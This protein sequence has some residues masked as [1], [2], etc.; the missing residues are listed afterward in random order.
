MLDKKYYQDKLCKFTGDALKNLVKQNTP[1]FQTEIRYRNGSPDNPGGTRVTFERQGPLEIVVIPFYGKEVKL[2]FKFGHERGKVPQDVLTKFD[3]NIDENI[4][5]I[6]IMFD[7][8]VN[9]V[10]EQEK[11]KS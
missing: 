7:H 10:Y 1:E 11:L 3:E 4:K 6:A 9:E 8:V 5:K 2:R